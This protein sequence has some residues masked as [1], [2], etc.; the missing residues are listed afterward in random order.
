MLCTEHLPPCYTC[1]TVGIVLAT[2]V[3]LCLRLFIGLFLGY[4]RH[5]HVLAELLNSSAAH[6]LRHSKIDA[7]KE[8]L[9][10]LMTSIRDVLMC[11]IIIIIIIIIYFPDLA[12]I[13]LLN[14]A[15]D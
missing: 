8:L 10:L 7:V 12:Y 6:H 4:I 3:L 11:V 5:V 9:L 1:D 13:K 14:N 2:T 15:G